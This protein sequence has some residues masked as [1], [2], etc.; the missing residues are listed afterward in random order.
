MPY[1][2]YMSRSP[3]KIPYAC[4]E[5][6]C[7]MSCRLASG[8]VGDII[9]DSQHDQPPKQKS[10]RNPGH[11]YA[12]NPLG[13]EQGLIVVRRLIEPLPLHVEEVTALQRDSANAANLISSDRT[14]QGDLAC[15]GS[16]A[17]DGR[18]QVKL[19]HHGGN[20]ADVGILVVGVAAGVVALVLRAV[21]VRKI[22]KQQYQAGIT[23]KDLP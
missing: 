7:Q 22:A 5:Y 16:T 3:W 23:G 21:R 19:L 17:D 1:P 11:A 6:R 15:H 18:L 12:I 14:S 2:K 10:G 8:A 9:W 4:A 13:V 20:A